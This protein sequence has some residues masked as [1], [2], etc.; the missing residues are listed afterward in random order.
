[1]NKI[2]KAIVALLVAGAVSGCSTT[3]GTTDVGY[4][5]VPLKN[6]KVIAGD[7]GGVLTTYKERAAEYR[8]NGTRVVIDGV[9]YSACMYLVSSLSSSNVCA[10]PSADLGFHAPYRIKTAGQE[11]VYSEDAK[12][13]SRKNTAEFLSLLPSKIRS[14]IL[15][16]GY[17]SVYKGDSPQKMTHIQGQEA[18][19]ILGKC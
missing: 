1:M 16:R 5:Y 3:S 13:E 14:K 19:N 9:C 15:S 12:A 17:P 18:M 6:D 2:A 10:T 4:V 7:Y 8:R 11:V